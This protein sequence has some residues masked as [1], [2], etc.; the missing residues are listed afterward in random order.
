MTTRLRWKRFCLLLLLLFGVTGTAFA[1]D[2]LRGDNCTIPADQVIEGTLFVLCETLDIRGTVTGDI[3]GA[4]L[5]G[6][7]A[8]DIQG[9]IYLLGGEIKLGGAVAGDVNFAG[10]SLTLTGDVPE[11]ATDTTTSPSTLPITPPDASQ[12]ELVAVKIDGGVRTLALDTRLV[13]AELSGGVMTIGYQLLVHSPVPGEVNFWGGR[14]MLDASVAGSVYANVGDP[15]SDSAQIE[16]LLLPFSFQLELS[17]PGLEITERGNVAGSLHYTGPVA[18]VIPRRLTQRTEY[19]PTTVALPTFE[20]PATLTIYFDQFTRSMTMLLAIGLLC[21]LFAPEL[22]RAPLMNMRYRPVSSFSVGMLAFLLSF[23]IVLI[24]GMLSLIV[25]LVLYAV[26][27]SGVAAAVGILLLVLNFSGIGLFYFVAIFVARALVAYALGRSLVRFFRGSY[28]QDTRSVVIS[29]AIGAALLGLAVSLPVI[30]WMFNAAAVFLGL[31]TILNAVLENFRR[32]RETIPPQQPTAWSP[33]AG[34][35]LR[36]R[37]ADTTDMPEIIASDEPD[38]DLPSSSTSAPA[39]V[40]GI[41]GME[42]LPDGFDWRFF[43]EK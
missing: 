28:V 27:L 21:W 3:I 11:P 10:L 2:I 41:S 26:N 29:M 17:D 5:R 1:R 33:L 31:G 42:N 24:V 8:G 32:I 25:F 6:A 30:G 39:P 22:L 40:R 15:A 23:P 37:S 4:S 35:T 13:D 7:I 14:L 38:E 18:A 9:S 34:T 43:D 36:P 19:T 16:T 20:E 12:S